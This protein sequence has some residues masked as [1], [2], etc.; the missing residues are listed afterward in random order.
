[1]TAAHL[2]LDEKP[3]VRERVL[4]TGAKLTATDRNKAYGP[5]VHNMQDIAALWHTY[6]CGRGLA[7]ISKPVSGEDVAH[8]M[9]LMKI[10]RTYQSGLHPDNYVD[11]AVYQAIAAECAE[12]EREA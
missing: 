12:S 1:M 9:T 11:S 3:S 10:A 2:D 5:P 6:L 4:Y 7:H 8:M